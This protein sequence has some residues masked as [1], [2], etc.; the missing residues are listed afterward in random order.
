MANDGTARVMSLTDGQAKMSK[1]HANDHSRINLLDSADVIAEKIKKCKTD[2]WFVVDGVSVVDNVVVVD[3][4][5]EKRPEAANL[6]RIYQA[7]TN[8][9]KAQ[10]YKEVSLFVCL[11]CLIIQCDFSFDDSCKDKVGV[12]SNHC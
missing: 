5:E 11:F 1:S 9:T 7:V 2:A 8:Q 6:L 3:I 10:V 12:N 4:D